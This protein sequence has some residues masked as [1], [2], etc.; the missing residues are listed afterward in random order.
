M[1]IKNGNVFNENGEFEIKD[2]Y[3]EDGLIVKGQENVSDDEFIDAKNLYVIPGLID[4]HSHGAVGHD[5]CDAKAEGLKKI[6]EYEKSQ[7]ITSY[8]PTTMT[9]KKEDLLNIF[10]V[11]AN[12]INYQGGA[13]IVGFNMEGPFIDP[14]KVGAQNPKYLNDCDMDFFNECNLAA[15]HLIKLITISPNST[16]SLEFIEKVKDVVSVSI[17]HT[18][19]DYETAKLAFSKGANHVTH[20]F[21]AMPPFNHRD[22]GVIGAAF[23]SDCYVELICDGIHIHPC[24]IKAVFTLFKNKVVLIS[25]S[26]MAAGMEDGEYQLGGQKVF[27][28]NNCATLKDGT[29]AGSSTNLFKCFKNAIEF[30]I[31]IKDAIFAA[32]ANPAKSIGIFD[33]VGSLSVGKK[34]NILLLDKE[35]NLV[36]V[37]K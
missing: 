34:A 10:S 23:D 19:A 5:F 26:M 24:V 13:D 1:V 32:T 20:L 35:F 4:I 30:G 11:G 36:K 27:V 16:K 7:G 28:K 29:I 12:L 37:I 14:N 17:G 18:T 21:N 31:P 2:L 25:D 6:L 9:L 3:I 15:N 8:C 22:P 33:T